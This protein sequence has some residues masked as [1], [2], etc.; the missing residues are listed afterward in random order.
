MYRILI[1]AILY[2]CTTFALFSQNYDFQWVG[3]LSGFSNQA[4]DMA[5]HD[6]YVYVTGFFNSNGD[7]DPGPGADT[8]L[9]GQAYVLKLDLA[10]NYIWATTLGEPGGNVIPLAIEVDALGDIIVTGYFTN[11]VDFDPGPGTAI[12]V[13]AAEDIFITKLDGNGTFLWKNTYFATDYERG[14]DVVTDADRNIYISGKIGSQPIDFDTGPSTYYVNGIGNFDVY[15]HKL[16]PAGDLVWAYASGGG[17]PDLVNS[18]EIG[19]DNNLYLTGTFNGSFDADF[20]ANTSVINGTPGSLSIF[21]VKLDTASNL[22]AAVTLATGAPQKI[23]IALDPMNNVC[24]TGAMDYALE[25]YLS[26]GT[27]TLSNGG[28]TIDCFVSK[29]N[30]SL[31]PLWAERFGSTIG[32]DNIGSTVIDQFGNIYNAGRAEGNVNVDP[33][34]TYNLSS[35]NTKFFVQKLDPNGNFIWAFTIPG[36]SYD[37]VNRRILLDMDRNIYLTG[38]I[39]Q[40][41]ADFDPSGG[42]ANIT[43]NEFSNSFFVKYGQC[44]GVAIDTVSACGSFTWIDSITYYSN[45]STASYTIPNGAASGCDSVV[46]LNLSITSV[47]TSVAQVSSSIYSNSNNSLYQWLDCDNNYALISGETSQAFTPLAN[48]NYA[49]EVTTNGCTDTS[50]CIPVTYFGIQ[51]N[52]IDDIRLYPNPT[53]GTLNIEISGVEKDISMLRQIDLSGRILKEEKL[54]N[55][56]STYAFDLIGTSGVYL[57]ELRSSEGYV[58]LKRVVKDSE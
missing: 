22:L 56:N 27:V 5:I 4:M 37:V 20:S 39:A 38:I 25:F 32:E 8:L 40:G 23:N 57:L 1:S 44:E 43:C 42:V 10:G 36:S 34:G 21:V 18:M 46:Y 11:T 29:L 45:N 13:S 53:S 3:S 6:N 30:S 41:S 54:T 12:G 2:C 31:D 26:S 35:W 17:G 48:G 58:G 49:V 28:S 50:A 16:T 9:G 33:N 14:V 7:F 19:S 51:E 55:V 52:L 47:D 24:V 15:I